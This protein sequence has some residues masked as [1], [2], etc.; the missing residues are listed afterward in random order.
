MKTY[1]SFF[2]FFSFTSL[3]FGQETISDIPYTENNFED[4]A[5]LKKEI[6][7][8]TIICLGEEWH[9]TETF[10][11]VKNRIVKYLHSEL[12]FKYILFESSIYSAAIAEQEMLKGEE[13]LI[14]TVQTIWRTESVLD[15]IHYIDHTKETDKAITQFGFDLQ[16]AYTDRFSKEL[17]DIT[18]R[19]NP[20]LVDELTRT[21]TL[22]Q[23]EWIRIHRSFKNKKSIISSRE[24][25]VY[26]NLKKTIESSSEKYFYLMDKD[27]LLWLIENR[28]F[29]CNLLMDGHDKFYREQILSKN[30]EWM[31][32]HI[33]E[34]EKNIIWAADIHIT[35][36]QAKT[37]KGAKKSMLELLP[38]NIQDK[39]FSLSLIPVESLPKKLKKQVNKLPQRFL[40]YPISEDSFL[41][42]KYSEFDAQIICK[43]TE[44]IEHFMIK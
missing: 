41:K 40:Y 33:G 19:H 5:F 38:E 29:L 30:L 7:D 28:I 35:K 8:K 25:E 31:I 37:Y 34:D 1:F 42:H 16:G 18:S 13:R 15:L 12:G 36:N 10:S 6:G 24:I 2:L 3:S 43:R 23:K 26:Q 32:N 11:Q 4:L 9:R 20:D 22:I 17:I 21:E 39:I 14:E 27:Y 44:S